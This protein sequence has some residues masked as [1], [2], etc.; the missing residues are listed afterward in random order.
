MSR[1]AIELQ[2]FK[3]LILREKL[4]KMTVRNQDLPGH[5]NTPIRV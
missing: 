2:D 1:L 5:Q 3:A 4:I